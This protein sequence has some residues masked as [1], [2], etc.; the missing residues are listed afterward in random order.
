MANVHD[1]PSTERVI[2]YLHAAAGF[3]TKA[4]W[5]KAISKGFYSTWPLLTSKNV[6]KYFPESEETQKGHM[7]QMRSGVRKT[8][9]KIRFVMNGDEQEL[10][11]IDDSIRALQARKNDIRI[12]IY[13]CSESVYTD[14]TGQF[15]ITSRRHYKYIMVMCEIDGNQI[16]MEPMVN[17]KDHHIISAWKRLMERLKRQGIYPKHQYL[18]NEASEQYKKAIE[19][20]NMTYQLATPHMHRANIAERSIQTG[21]N[22]FKS[23]LAGVDD[24]F[25][26]NEWDMLLPQ[27]EMTLNMLRSSNVSPNVSAYMYAYGTHDYNAHPLAPLGCAVQLFQRPENRGTWSVNSIDGWYIGTSREHYRNYSVICKSTRAT[28]KSDTVWF[29]H[30]YLTNPS[31]TAADHIVNA[32]KNLTDT[33]TSNKPKGLSTS[34]NAALTKLA[35]IFTKAAIAYSDREANQNAQLPG[36]CDVWSKAGGKEIGRLAQGLPGVVEGTNTMFFKAYDEIPADRRKDV[37]YARIC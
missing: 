36:Y 25:P 20:A 24:S 21:K 7:R 15:P 27:A 12:K 16:L 1:L 19:E 28:R 3:P 8:N 17:R 9:R 32:A 2:R 35:D 6:N 13:D 26:L 31:L 23:I 34:S 30:K 10:E 14:Q 18:D 29:K 4:T 33:I 22:H 11:E 5:L 37:T